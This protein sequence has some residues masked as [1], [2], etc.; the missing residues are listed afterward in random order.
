MGNGQI[1]ERSVQLSTFIYL[2]G[3]K[4]ADRVFTDVR[5][6]GPYFQLSTNEGSVYPIKV[7]E[8]SVTKSIPVNCM[9]GFSHRYGS[10]VVCSVFISHFNLDFFSDDQTLIND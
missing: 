4:I 10:I 7:L 1:L 8:I 9:L 6:S 2:F 5:L 3:A